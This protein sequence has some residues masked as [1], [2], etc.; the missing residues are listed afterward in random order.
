MAEA[1][2]VGF[3]WVTKAKE[4]GAVI[5]HVDPRY[6]RTSAMADIWVPIRAGSD[7]AFLGG[8]IHFTLEQNRFF[9]E[10]VAQY[11]N[12]S[13]L[14]KPE[15]RDTEE[16]AGYF[17][18]WD[19]SKR[20]YYPNTWLYEGDDLGHPKR[21]LTIQHPRCVF[22]LLRRHYSRYT[23]EMVQEVTGCPPDLFFR[24][25]EAFTNA[26]GPERTAAICYA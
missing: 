12:A 5:I 11:T 26:S 15:F 9:R 7:I 6:S 25:A 24:V 4:N 14:L 1:H 16:G 3:R 20:A 8:L 17:S 18:G 10:Y 21:D 2:P 19:E 23:P 13:C 22:Q